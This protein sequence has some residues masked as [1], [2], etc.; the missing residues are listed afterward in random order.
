MGETSPLFL[1]ASS[2][3]LNGRVRKKAMTSF[4]RDR[5]LANLSPQLDYSVS[6]KLCCACQSVCLSVCLSVLCV[7]VSACVCV[8]VCV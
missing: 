3:R 4:E 5:T 1:S 7:C 2:C 8:I 6:V